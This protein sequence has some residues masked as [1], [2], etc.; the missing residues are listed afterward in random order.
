M[1][2]KVLMRHPT[3]GTVEV[4]LGFSWPA[5]FLGPLWAIVKRLWLVL[6]LLILASLAITLVDA[7]S[8]T[9]N[10][11][12]LTFLTLG[13]SIVYVYVCGKYGNKW[14]RWTLE[15]RGFQPMSDN[16]EP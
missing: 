7:L 15:R 8:D 11:V 2:Q 12:A 13:L 14:W 9:Q 5:F 6:A 1:K 10:S 4:P 16:N 3:I